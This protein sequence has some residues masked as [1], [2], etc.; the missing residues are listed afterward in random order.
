MNT[1]GVAMYNAA[2]MAALA[3]EKA[4]SVSTDGIRKALEGMTF[5]GAPQGSITMRA[6]DHQAVLPSY[7][8]QVQPKWTSTDTMFKVVNTVASVTPQT[9]QCTT[10]PL[11]KA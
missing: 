1:V 7:L 2:H 4:G 6:L 9:A 11:S 8:A 10:L 3:I 5:T